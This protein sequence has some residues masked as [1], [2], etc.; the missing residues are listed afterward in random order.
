MKSHFFWG[1]EQVAFNAAGSKQSNSYHFISVE[2]AFKR[3]SETILKHY[4]R[5]RWIQ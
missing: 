2:C 5:Q 4:K 3:C 1:I